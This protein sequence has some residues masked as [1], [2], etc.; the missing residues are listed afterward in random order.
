MDEYPA[1]RGGDAEAAHQ[2]QLEREQMALHALLNCYRAGASASDL[3]I[4]AAE[5]GLT[6]EWQQLAR[7]YQ[8]TI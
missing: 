8:P 5:I 3:H 4:L 1:P 2:L 6:K 7:T